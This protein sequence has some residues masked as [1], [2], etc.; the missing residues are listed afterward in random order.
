MYI[1]IYR[2]IHIYILRANPTL[3]WV[4][5]DCHESLLYLDMKPTFSG[6]ASG[7]NMFQ[8][9]GQQGRNNKTEEHLKI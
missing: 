2:F 7:F 8:P 5:I 6:S 1:Y 4:Y 3:C 9:L